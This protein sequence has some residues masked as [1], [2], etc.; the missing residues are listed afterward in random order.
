MVESYIGAMLFDMSAL[1]RRSKELGEQLM[2]GIKQRIEEAEAKFGEREY[3]SLSGEEMKLISEIKIDIRDEFS[4]LAKV[5]DKKEFEEY[6]SKLDDLEKKCMESK[7]IPEQDKKDIS[8]YL[9][10][11]KDKREV[12]AADRFI[13]GFNSMEDKYKL[14]YLKITQNRLF[15]ETVNIADLEYNDKLEAQIPALIAVMPEEFRDRYVD[16]LTTLAENGDNDCGIYCMATIIAKQFGLIETNEVV[17]EKPIQD[18][19]KDFYFEVAKRAAIG[20]PDYDYDV[21]KALPDVLEKNGLDETKKIIDIA[22]K[23]KNEDWPGEYNQILFYIGMKAG[24]KFCG[25]DEEQE[26]EL[27]RKIEERYQNENKKT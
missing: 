13:S 21:L 22:M 9:S 11:K 18:E 6:C 16:V 3:S 8:D 5:R 24:Y 25:I 1:E 4:R 7:N 15:H 10:L 14:A 27:V 20:Q 26:E 19:Y 2:D 17:G 23:I 12:Y